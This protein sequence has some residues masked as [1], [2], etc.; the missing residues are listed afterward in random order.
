METNE[1]IREERDRLRIAITN[2]IVVLRD[3]PDTYGSAAY[4]LNMLMCI[5]DSWC[6]SENVDKEQLPPLGLYD[7]GSDESF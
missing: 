7:P 1:N 6:D 3:E 5:A 4:V 2:A